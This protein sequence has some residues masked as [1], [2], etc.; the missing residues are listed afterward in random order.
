MAKKNKNDN[1]VDFQKA[2]NKASARKILK[3]LR[4]P[5]AVLVAIIIFA[6]VFIAMGETRRSNIADSFKA[7]PATMGDSKGYPYSE[8]ELN[9][10]KVMLVGDKPLVIS[11]TAIQVLSQDADILQ[12]IYPDWADTRAFSQNGRAVVYSNTSSKALLISRTDTLAEFNE[13]G[14]I[15]TGTVGNNGSVALSYSTDKVQSVVKVYSPRQKAEFQWNC[16]RDYVA[17]LSLSSDGNKVLISALGVENAAIYSRVVLF[18][19]GKTEPKFD[20]KVE[21]TSILKVVYASSN[22][23]VAIGDN[24]TIIFNAKGEQV[25][26]IEYSADSLYTIDSDSKGNTLLCYKE[27]GGSKIMIVKIPSH[28]N[29]KSFE[30]DYMPSSITLRESRIAAALDNKVTVYSASGAEKTTYECKN[31]VSTVLITSAGIYTLENGTI[32]KY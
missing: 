13:E 23:L 19:T 5:L 7:I 6:A 12:E 26:E 14:T 4:I 30:I 3:K 17:S 24:K 8:D 2:K 31:N 28:G 15:V 25:S 20:V 21:G 27:Y 10:S 16:S 9:L 22:R 1:T 32:Y 18:K 11:E 29:I